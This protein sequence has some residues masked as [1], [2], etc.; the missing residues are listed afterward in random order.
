M[1]SEQSGNAGQGHKGNSQHESESPTIGVGRR[2]SGEAGATRTHE[3]MAETGGSG[4]NGLTG[5]QVGGPRQPADERA[6]ARQAAESG[7]PGD[8]FS[9]GTG[10]GQARRPAPG[11]AIDSGARGYQ[12]TRSEQAGGSETGLGTPATGANQNAADIERSGR[13]RRK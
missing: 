1:G 11:S 7:A 8:S 4:G 9:P 6:R 13:E 5:N 10:P 12:D 3:T 2:T